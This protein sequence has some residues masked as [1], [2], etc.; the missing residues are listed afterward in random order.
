MVSHYEILVNYQ[1][2][3][4]LGTIAKRIT[5]KKRY[6]NLKTSTH[7]FLRITRILTCLGEFGFEEWKIKLIDHFIK[8][9]LNKKI[10][11]YYS[12]KNCRRSL[13]EYWIETIKDEK[14]RYYFYLSLHLGSLLTH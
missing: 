2:N 6:R 1:L 3:S 4:N 11:P 5:W 10:S 8:E 9:V 12:I 14:L 7:N 13:E